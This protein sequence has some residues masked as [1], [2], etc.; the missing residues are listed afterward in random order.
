LPSRLL[1]RLHR[2]YAIWQKPLPKRA[3]QLTELHPFDRLEYERS[4]LEPYLVT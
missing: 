2:S 1:P 4:D 3:M